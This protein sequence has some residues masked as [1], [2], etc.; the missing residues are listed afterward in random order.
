[1]FTRTYQVLCD[2]AS[3]SARPA[4]FLLFSQAVFL[5]FRNQANSKY[6]TWQ[7]SVLRIFVVK[8]ALP[9]VILFVLFKI[10]CHT[11]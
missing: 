1:M 6:A 9:E 5:F 11:W 3:E 10:F 7:M 2:I 4:D 8:S